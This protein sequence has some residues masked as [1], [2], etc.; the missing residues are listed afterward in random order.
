MKE[1]ENP[2][3]PES[4]HDISPTIREYLEKRNIEVG[5]T[6]VSLF[7]GVRIETKPH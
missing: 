7:E 3:S 2:L 4:D 6:Q 5:V 1:F